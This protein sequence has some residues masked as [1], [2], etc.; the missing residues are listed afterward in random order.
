MRRMPAIVSLLALC[1]ML[2]QQP[3]HAG[4]SVQTD[5]SKG[6]GVA[7]IGAED[8]KTR[9][10]S[11]ERVSVVDVRSSESFSNSDQ[12]IR[13]AVHMKV[14]RIEHRLGFPPM[15]D[16]PR[17]SLVVTYCSCP[18]DESSIAAARILLQNGFTN[19]RVLKGGWREW[20]KVS[21][22]T[23]KKPRL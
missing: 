15:K 19:V 23:E 17:Q 20:V 3:E 22:Q 11:G 18:A 2:L 8:L 1:C 6:P 12:K 7:F 16:V 21:G 4:A 5:K 10:A 14:R 13:G 9:I